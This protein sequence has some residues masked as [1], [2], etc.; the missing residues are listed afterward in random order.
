M[1]VAVLAEI[2]AGSALPAD[3]PDVVHTVDGG[4]DA[5][6]IL[7][8]EAVDADLALLVPGPETVGEPA[9]LIDELIAV[10]ALLARIGGLVGAALHDTPARVE[11]EPPGAVDALTA[12]IHL[13][14]QFDGVAQA[15]ALGEEGRQTLAAA[16]LAQRLAVADPAGVVLERERREALRAG[17]L[18][19]VGTSDDLAGRAQSRVHQ[20]EP[21]S[22]L[23]AVVLGC[24]LRTALNALDAEALSQDK[25]RTAVQALVVVLLQAAGQEGL[26]ASA[27]PE[28]EAVLASRA[29]SVCCEFNTA[30]FFIF[31][32]VAAGTFDEVV[33]ELA[34]GTLRL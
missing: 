30:L 25:V 15:V 34:L 1:A 31:F 28:V 33:I 26:L 8:P 18:G 19:L 22:A 14:A 6:S 12:D 4:L 5:Q 7:N 24:V 32:V 27:V 10:L 16:E 9:C 29:L 17:A 11:V 20:S 13:A 2:E 3:L 23:P 21:S